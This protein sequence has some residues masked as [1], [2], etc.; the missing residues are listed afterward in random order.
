MFVIVTE[1]KLEQI[2]APLV[3]ICGVPSEMNNIFYVFVLNK[4]EII[5]CDLGHR[6]MFFSHFKKTI[7]FI[8][9]LL[10]GFYIVFLLLFTVE[11]SLNNDGICLFY[12]SYFSISYYVSHMFFFVSDAVIVPGFT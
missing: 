4:Y 9:C 8:F 7:Q 1:N 3:I 6:Y 12:K 10:W 11:Y 5:C 2:P